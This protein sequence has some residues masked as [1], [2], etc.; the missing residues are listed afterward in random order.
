M[1]DLQFTP[2]NFTSSNLMVFGRNS[3]AGT[4]GRC[5]MAELIIYNRR[6]TDSERRS[7]ENYLGARYGI[8]ITS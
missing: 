5:I 3:S 7:V 1:T 4:A 2:A 8:A 6:L